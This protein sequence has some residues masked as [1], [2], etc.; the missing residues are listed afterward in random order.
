M[1]DHR[2]FLQEDADTTFAQL[3]RRGVG[4]ALLEKLQQTASARRGAV[5]T[6]EHLRQELNRHSADVEK[7]VKAGDKAGMEASRAALKDLKA[8]I[9]TQEDKQTELEQA[10]DALLMQ[11]PNLPHGSV[12]DGADESANRTERVVGTPR[13]FDF[14][15]K[16]HDELGEQLGILDFARA[17]AMSGARFVVL[18]GAGA[19]LERALINMMLDMARENGC[20]EI[21]PPLLVRPDAMEVAGQYP[22]FIGESF[23][24]RDGE[25]V[26]I[27]TSEVALVNLHRDEI[28]EESA[29]PIRYTAYT[30]CFRREAGAAG[31]DTR[32]L[33]RLHQFNKVELVAFTTPEHSSEEL[34]R[35]TRH[36]GSILERL[37]LPY[38]VVSLCTGD[39]GFAAAKTYDLE[40]WLPSQQCYREISSCSND[41]DFQARRGKI[42]YRPANEGPKAKPRLV[43]TLNGSGIAVGRCFVAILE[44]YQQ[45]DGSVAIP[46]ALVPYFGAER[47]GP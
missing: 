14:A 47:I 34:E 41:T 8:Q 22:K 12:P 19:R 37:E 38:R 35:I 24:T 6:V 40:V 9:K 7:Q 33:V 17:S 26:L 3:A 2:L 1:L 46:K 44:N 30:P 15:P 18:K 23:E 20:E 42:R 28:I 25:L 10:L 45:A 31:R 29:L 16:A 36:A 4:R 11:I 13:V 32:G 5:Q 39:L 21:F 43:H 27:P